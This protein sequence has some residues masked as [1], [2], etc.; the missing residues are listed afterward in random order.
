MIKRMFKRAGALVL[1][2]AMAVA[3][4]PKIEGDDPVLADGFTKTSENTRLCTGKISNPE[5]PD[6]KNSA[7]SGSYV[8]FGKNA[9]EPIRFRVLNNNSTAYGGNTLFLDSDRLFDKHIFDENLSGWAD[10]DLREYFNGEFIEKYFSLEESK[11]IFA[12]TVASHDYSDDIVPVQDFITSDYK[13]YTALEGDKIFPLDFEE[14]SNPLYGYHKEDGYNHKK[15]IINPGQYD[16][17]VWWLRT[18]HKDKIHHAKITGISNVNGSLTNN[19]CDAD[20]YASPALN[21]DRNKILF[22]TLLSGEEGKAGAEYKLTIEDDDIQLA[23]PEGQDAKFENGAWTVPYILSGKNA[24][25]VNQLSVMVLSKDYRGG[26]L[27]D[28]NLV[29]YAKIDATPSVNGTVSFA[30]PSDLSSQYMWGAGYQLYLVAENVNGMM[31]TDYSSKPLLIE[32][33]GVTYDVRT[34]LK[35]DPYNFALFSIIAYGGSIN[36]DDSGENILFDI[37]KDDVYDLS[38]SKGS[39]GATYMSKLDDCILKG[40]YSLDLKPVPEKVGDFHIRDISIILSDYKITLNDINNGTATL[41]KT[42]A[43]AGDEISITV[44]PE[45]GYELDKITYKVGDVVTD[46]TDSKKFTMPEDD[47]TVDVVFKKTAAP[48]V[49]P[50]TA[51]AATATPTATTKPAAPTATVKP[52]VTSTPKPTKPSQVSLTLDKSSANVICGKALTINATL[53]GSTSKI[54]WKSSD[55]KVAAVDATGKITAKMAGTVTI[56]ATAAGKSASCKVTVLYKDVTNSK[57]FWYAP[58]NYLTAKGVVKGYANQTEFRPANN[59][60]R[61]QMVTFIW[62]LQGEPKPKTT[63]CKFSDVKKTD[64]FYKACIWG[65]ENHIVEGYKDGTFGPQIVCARKHA[66]TFLWRLAGQPAPKTKTNKFTDVK[67]KDYFYKAT[68]WASEKGILAGYSDGTFRPNGDCLRRQMVTFLYKYD[69]FVNG[70][71]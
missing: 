8:Y 54:T 55:T 56:T 53:K 36:F 33:P 47:V 64:Y 35:I 9:G 5:K 32:N 43:Q 13:T 71:G 37:D 51:P 66:V 2:S 41:S 30:L 14:V 10:S 4:I 7:W 27:G 67:E 46:I 21:L 1:A 45:S 62:R 57:D 12:S 69:K 61:A 38:L 6:N 29:Y 40:R 70:K 52:V 3:L 23:L 28:P 16:Q 22:S 49:T 48:S 20:N 59:C 15:T 44:N 17:N 65:N 60:T 11:V 24:G 18:D 68:L 34:P 26:D 63:K 42:E 58:T 39:D 25:S 31:E 50:T 19:P